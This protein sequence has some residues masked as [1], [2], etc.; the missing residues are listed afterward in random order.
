[1]DKEMK[2]LLEEEIKSMIQNLSSL[3]SGSKEKSTAIDDLVKLYKLRI[4]ETKNEWD[5]KES[6]TFM[7]AINN[8]RKP[9]SKNRLKIDILDWE[10]KQQE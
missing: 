4:E 8:S 3:P 6:I 5:F 10:W 7:K 1:M 2:D 9:S